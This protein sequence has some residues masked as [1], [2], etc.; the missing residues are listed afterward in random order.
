MP[1][2]NLVYEENKGWTVAKYLLGHERMGLGAVGSSKRE[3]AALKALAA[4]ETKNGKPLI[5][6]PRFR[7][8]LSRVE[9]ERRA[10]THVDALSR[11]DAPRPDARAQPDRDLRGLAAR[12]CTQ[13]SQRGLDHA[14]G[15]ASPAGMRRRHGRPSGAARAPAGSRRL[16]RRRR[17]RGRWSRQRRSR[18]APRRPCRHAGGPA[19]PAPMHLAQPQRLRAQSRRRSGAVLGHGRRIVA[20][21]QPRFRLPQGAG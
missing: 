2:E 9:I 4:Q 17:R 5:D 15:Q 13:R 20:D 1:V 18:A 11:Q 14:T 7:D 8:R 10:G 12:R 6:D 3:L 21:R 19:R 16:V